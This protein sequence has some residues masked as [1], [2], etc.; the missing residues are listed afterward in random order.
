MLLNLHVKNLALIEEVDVDFEKGLIVLTGETGAGKS[1]ILGSINIALGNKATKEIIR[2]G[3]DYA[4]V[5]LT[6]SVDEKSKKKLEE[7]DINIDDDV[8]TVSRKITDRRSVAKINGETVNVSILRNVM[9]ELVDIYGQHDH[10]S[11]LYKNKHLE[12]LDEF[13]SAEIGSLK[14]NICLKYK[15]YLLLN[16]KLKN[17]EYD[18]ATRMRELELIKFEV[19]EIDNAELT[20]GEDEALEVEYKKISNSQNIIENLAG[21]EQTLSE[22]Q[23]IKDLISSCIALINDVGS[24]DEKVRSIRDE[25]YNI[26]ALIQD[27]SREVYDY[28]VN[29]TINPERL[30]EIE[31]RLD[32]INHLKLKYGNNISEILIYRNKKQEQLDMLLNY[33]ENLYLLKEEISVLEKYITGLCCE[34]SDIRSKAALELEKLVVKALKDLNFLQVDFKIQISRKNSF[35]EN[36]FDDIEFL[37]ST[38]PGEP[39]RSIGKVA[40]GGE[41]SRIMLALK[42]ILANED[43]I[44][45]L[46]FDEVDTGV[47]GRTAGMVANKLAMISRMRQVICISHL[48][49]IASMADAHYL[50]EKNIKDNETFTNIVKLSYEESIEELVRISGGSEITESAYIH[51]KEMKEVADRTKI[52]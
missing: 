25:L 27:L 21:I 35:N 3:K 15:E 36:G 18:E 52:S 12:I 6:F 37:I 45:T 29:I 48:A 19:D 31:K 24:D 13:A 5:E 14:T 51:A 44:D 9:S 20:V 4:L 17:F 34:L 28:S 46:I 33:E 38:N 11:L 30:N 49:Q 26:E 32:L 22:N 23:G 47:S 1:L 41:L 10:Q 40:S 39:V 16:E 8:I 43:N 7:Y 50:I 42:S 2:Q